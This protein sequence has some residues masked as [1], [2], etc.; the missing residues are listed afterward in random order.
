MRII[1]PSNKRRAEQDPGQYRS[2]DAIV[3]KNGVQKI[4]DER[5]YECHYGVKSNHTPVHR[6][7]V[8]YVHQS[9]PLFATL[10]RVRVCFAG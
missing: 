2:N 7:P 4:C 1:V 6:A 3:T 9:N 8:N 5:R 10:D